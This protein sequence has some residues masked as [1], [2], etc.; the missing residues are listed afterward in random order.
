MTRAFIALP[1][2]E[3]IRPQLRLLQAVLPLPA[4]VEPEDFHLTLAFLGEQPDH[5][6]QDIHEGLEALSM[7]PFPL[8]L[9]GCDTFGGAKP[10]VIWAGVVPSEPLVRLQAKVA[11][12]AVRAG[13]PIG[14]KGFVP[15]VT[16]GRFRTPDPDTVARLERAIV[17]QQ[18]FRAGPW[19]AA[20]FA[21]YASH[22]RTH[23]PKYEI[24]SDYPLR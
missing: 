4:W 20:D 1:I 10:R 11:Q 8:E 12:V 14:T 21:L 9:S 6:L 13:V 19:L 3:D 22:P 24:L 5:V 23:G 16:L 18:G 17:A 2:P 7:P 15:H